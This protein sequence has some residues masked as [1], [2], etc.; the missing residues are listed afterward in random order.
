MSFNI[1]SYDL[2]DSNQELK[3]LLDVIQ[4]DSDTL[5][6][7]TGKYE[8][9]V[10]TRRTEDT[11]VQTSSGSL[12][13]TAKKVVE[14]VT[15]VPKNLILNVGEIVYRLLSIPFHLLKA[16]A[17]GAGQGITYLFNNSIG[18]SNQ[19]MTDITARSSESSHLQLSPEASRVST[20]G[21]GG[22][23]ANLVMTLRDITMIL[24]CLC[25]CLIRNEE[26][27]TRIYNEP[28]NKTLNIHYIGPISRANPIDVFAFI[29]NA[30]LTNITETNID[31]HN[32]AYTI[33]RTIQGARYL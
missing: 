7:P 19:R 23:I 28:I 26:R 21:E 10:T 24:G 12:Y 9:I 1:H 18:S 3:T 30:F 27:D 14:A 31:S 6:T 25:F 4:N 5:E 29:G 22:I 20:F 8:E 13:S 16:C 2:R 15:L 32:H 17:S 33:D 11:P